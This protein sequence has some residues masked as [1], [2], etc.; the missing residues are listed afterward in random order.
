[1]NQ[2]VSNA[3][4]KDN[5]F[6]KI[7]SLQSE[8]DRDQTTVDAIFGRALDLTKSIGQSADN[9]DPLMDKLERVK[10]LIWDNSEKVEQ[11]P[12]QERPKL[13]TKQETTDQAID[14][15]DDIPF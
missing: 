2:E 1:M 4:K 10:R 8:I 12:K 5:I 13:I 3:N 15:D 11:L 14:L 7:A 6:K 9:L